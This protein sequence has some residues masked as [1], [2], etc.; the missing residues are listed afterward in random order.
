MKIEDQI[1]EEILS[2]VPCI[3][4]YNIS[5]PGRV[6]NRNIS[7]PIASEPQSA[8]AQIRCE[9]RRRET[10]AK[11]VLADILGYEGLFRFAHIPCV[12]SELV[13]DYAD[14]VTTMAAWERRPETKA[15][16][17]KIKSLMRE[18][19]KIHDKFI[20][21]DYRKLENDN[22]LTFEEGVKDIIKTYQLSL[23]GSLM[24]EYPEMDEN[25]ILF[26]TAVYHCHIVLQAL[27]RYADEQRA[28]VERLVGH[29]IGNIVSRPVR[30]LSRLI[31]LYAGGKVV[32]KQF[33]SLQRIYIKVL[34]V[35][36][37]LIQMVDSP[38]P[39]H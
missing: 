8:L 1:F 25:S 17:R 35:Q 24:R 37:A 31:P 14:T 9:K 5:D 34:S 13:W 33:M 27:L 20:G 36:M 12:I 15:L 23:R 10:R 39:R 3:P 4:T 29:A 22:M 11:E 7:Q 2:D 30:E 21:A 28:E 32:S 18:Y 6:L 16:N 26:L 19:D 38:G